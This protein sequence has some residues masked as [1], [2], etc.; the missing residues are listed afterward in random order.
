MSA[1]DI[2]LTGAG[3]EYMETA[4]LVEWS[5]AR[6]DSVKAG[7]VV[8][9]VE[10]AKAATEIFAPIDGVVSEIFVEKGTEIAVGSVLG[11]I[12]DAAAKAPSKPEAVDDPATPAP[13]RELTPDRREGRVAASPLARRLAAARGLD[14]RTV[15]G[16][17]PAGRIKRRDVEA[18]AQAAPTQIQSPSSHRHG[19]TERDV[20]LVLLHGFASDRR[21][22][23]PLRSG[24]SG[25][26]LIALDLAG[27][28]RCAA[29]EADSLD[30]LVAHVAAGLAER[31]LDEVHL[32]GHS[33]GGAVALALATSGIV[34]VRSL[35]LIAPAGFGPSIDRAFLDGILSAA[36]AE[37]LAPW[38]RHMVGDPA[39]I[40]DGYVRAAIEQRQDGRLIATQR[41][42]GDSL[43]PGGTQTFDVL[44]LLARLNMPMKLIWGLADRVLPPA[45]IDGLP[46]F[47]AHHRLAGIGHVPQLEDIT[48]VRRLLGELVQSAG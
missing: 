33:L 23:N 7:D 8:A 35:A 30:D 38:L 11:R 37:T 40:S 42:M 6:G 9:I 26:E 4:T 3:G 39:L 18:A 16:S 25:P 46:G 13:A 1:A 41:R 21:S 34:A 14:L 24:W 12:G 17:G 19:E 5:V 10:T 22:W 15:K 36:T 29:V 32:A 45:P 44:P 2:I 48:L 31:S 43:F 47:V 28:G 20:P 27:H